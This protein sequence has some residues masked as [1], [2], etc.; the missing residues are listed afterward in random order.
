M[1]AAMSIFRY[2]LVD[3]NDI[4]SVPSTFFSKNQRFS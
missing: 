1:L 4:I 2:C 3:L